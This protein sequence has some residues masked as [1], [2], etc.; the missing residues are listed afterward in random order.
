MNNIDKAFGEYCEQ[1]VKEA[2]EQTKIN[3]IFG[4]SIILISI[5]Y[6][7]AIITIAYKFLIF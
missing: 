7:I 4:S 5:F 2:K 6:L 3:I 1:I